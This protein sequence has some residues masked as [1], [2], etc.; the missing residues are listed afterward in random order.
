MTETMPERFQAPVFDWSEA[1]HAD[2]LAWERE[3]YESWCEEQ[4]S[5]AHV[6]TDLEDPL[7]D[8][9]AAYEYAV[10]CLESAYSQA[11]AAG[12]RI[13]KTPPVLVECSDL[14]AATKE[15][16]A[17]SDRLDTLD[18]AEWAAGIAPVV[19]LERVMESLRRHY[20]PAVVAA[21]K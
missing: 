4:E 12:A 9:Q 1:D 15:Y 19:A 16:T 13:G 14:M 17:A 20:G 2:Y 18:G 7:D 5:Q 10:W 8:P 21:C 11:V 3:A 6:D